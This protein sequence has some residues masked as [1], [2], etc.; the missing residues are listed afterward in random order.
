MFRIAS[1]FKWV[2]PVVCLMFLTA[3]NAGQLDDFETAA[4]EGDVEEID[5]SKCRHR[6]CHDEHHNDEN[7]LDDSSS[8]RFI[9]DIIS[10]IITESSKATLARVQSTADPVYEDI[11]LRI[12]GSPDLPMLRLDL[13]RQH[14]DQNL[15]GSDFSIEGGFGPLALQ[16]RETNFVEDS[17]T[18]LRMSYLHGLFR[19]SVSP[20]FEMDL[21]LGEVTLTGKDQHSG[22]SFTIPISFYTVSKLQIRFTPTWSNIGSN[23]IRDYDASVA[24]IRKYF[25]VRLGYR[26]L[27]ALH[28]TLQGPYVGVSLH[29]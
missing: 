2:V 13:N 29:Y 11:P 15:S 17:A 19:M 27:Q 16:Y 23:E 8:G 7:Y 20:Q 28:E 3:L 26:K 9:T 12:P 5:V 14:I 18:N 6:H 22:M 1:F 21:G 24:V 4:T 25:S 10:T